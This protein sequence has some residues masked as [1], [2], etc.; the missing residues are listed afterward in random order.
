MTAW[1]SDPRFC[2]C[3]CSKA[4]ALRAPSLKVMPPPL[5]TT[6]SRSTTLLWN[7]TW[8]LDVGCHP[9]LGLQGL[10]RE[11]VLCKAD[12]PAA[13]LSR[14]TMQELVRNTTELLV[15]TRRAR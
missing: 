8:L 2:C 5:S 14:K 11:N 4:G 15:G 9:H 1:Q 12:L 10:P 6:A 13:S 7:T 3:C